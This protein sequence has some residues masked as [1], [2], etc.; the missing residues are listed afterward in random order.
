MDPI[1]QK[2]RSDV[3]QFGWHVLNV[4]PSDEHP[5]HS[6]SVGVFASFGHPEIVIVG[7]PGERAH[8]FINNLVDEIKDGATFEAGSRYGHLIEGYDVLFLGVDQ[9]LFS[10]YFGRAIDFYGS[11]RFPVVQMTWPDRNG[12]F[13]WQAEC[14]E[15]IRKL[16]PVL[17]LPP[18]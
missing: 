6:Y 17:Q 1:E 18:N 11:S 7:L 14:E 12:M 3:E 2:L 9:A 4:L 16:Q 5:P 8:A 15:G 13:P 10:D